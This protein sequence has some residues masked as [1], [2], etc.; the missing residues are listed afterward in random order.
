MTINIQNFDFETTTHLNALK[1]DHIDS[2]ISHIKTLDNQAKIDE[3]FHCLSQ[4]LSM[5]KSRSP[6]KGK[7]ESVIKAHIYNFTK[8]YPTEA[9]NATL[10]ENF[11]FDPNLQET[12]IKV[13]YLT[14]PYFFS[15]VKKGIILETRF[16]HHLHKIL[17]EMDSPTST[18]GMAYVVSGLSLISLSGLAQSYSGDVTISEGNITIA[19]P[20]LIIGGLL[21]VSPLLHAL[22]ASFSDNP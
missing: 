4:T 7:C 22:R 9:L 10:N 2:L 17:G 5:N 18:R 12:I 11:K 3:L 1:Y 15:K 16:S 13:R 8:T 19:T 6:Y 20:A 21:T 14:K